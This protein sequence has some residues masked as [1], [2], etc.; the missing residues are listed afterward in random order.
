[1]IKCCYNKI[2]DRNNDEMEKYDNT[3]YDSIEYMMNEKDIKIVV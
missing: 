2:K 1:M 3:V